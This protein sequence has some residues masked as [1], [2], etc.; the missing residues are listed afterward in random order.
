MEEEPTGSADVWCDLLRSLPQHHYPLWGQ[1]LPEDGLLTFWEEERRGE[2]LVFADPCDSLPV[3]SRL[4]DHYGPPDRLVGS[5]VRSD[6]RRHVG[7]ALI[8]ARHLDK[9][10]LD[11]WLGDEEMALPEVEVLTSKWL[12]SHV[13]FRIVECDDAGQRRRWSQG[14]LAGNVCRQ[15]EL[16]SR[17]L[18][19]KAHDPRVAATGLWAPPAEGQTGL[20]PHE[21]AA[22][23]QAVE[24][25]LGLNA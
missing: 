14:L 8:R 25:S 4:E 11:Q 13:G 20:A 12:R 23:A 17:W 19:H 6:L 1:W 9:A 16:P 5:R 7:A 21:F 10:S 18:G 3:T 22:L 24:R 15:G 2:R